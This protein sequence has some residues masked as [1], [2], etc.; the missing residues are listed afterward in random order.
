MEHILL[1]RFFLQTNHK[2][3]H[4]THK[5]ENVGKLVNIFTNKLLLLQQLWLKQHWLKFLVYL[6][7]C[8]GY[9]GVK[10]LLNLQFNYFGFCKIHIFWQGH[11]ILQN[12]H[13]SWILKVS[14][15]QNLL[16][17][18]PKSTKKQ[19]NFCKDFCPIV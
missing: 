4:F 9:N 1:F 14:W 13:R 17:V 18:S 5:C 8:F 11:K 6:M 7:L 2:K 12:L 15:F 19:R 16:L 3:S 10:I